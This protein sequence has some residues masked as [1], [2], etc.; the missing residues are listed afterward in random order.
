MLELSE[1]ELRRALPASADVAL[2][3]ILRSVLEAQATQ[4]AHKQLK[5]ELTLD[6]GT[7]VQGDNF[8]LHLAIS[9]LISNAIEWSPAGATLRVSCRSEQGRAH[10]SIEDEGPGIP[11][12]A[13]ERVFERFYSLTRPD[14]GQ[15][16]TGLGLN[17]V[18]EI[19]TLHQ[20]EIQL[21]NRDQR[22]LRAVLSLPL[23]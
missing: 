10:I 1:L 14:T 20:G 21:E 15:K 11:E 17:L 9:N 23:G 4:I 18:R 2:T 22:G 12:F 5:T 3:P 16:S 8:Q 7:R 6:E 19:A 13:R